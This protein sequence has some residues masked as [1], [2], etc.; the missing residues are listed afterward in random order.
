MG[1]IFRG[2]GAIVKAG[3][4]TDSMSDNGY[5]VKYKI[6]L[7]IELP[8]RFKGSLGFP[9]GLRSLPITSCS[10][11]DLRRSDLPAIYVAHRW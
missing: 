5:Y 2:A 11:Q 6:S 3:N 10:G 9:K 8:E 1:W 4:P 7:I